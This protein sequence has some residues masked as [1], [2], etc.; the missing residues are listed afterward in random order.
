MPQVEVNYLAVLVAAIASMVL[1]GLWYGPLFGKKWMAYMGWAPD[2][3]QEMKKG[4]T[5]G[6]VFQFIGSLVMSYVLVHA[7]IFAGA[8]LKVSGLSAGL[9]AGF[10]NWLGF[11]APVT[12]GAV[13]W[14]GKPAGFWLLNN[15]FYLISL[16]AMGTI[17]A[18]WM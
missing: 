4:A 17:L 7:L 12:L 18:V 8:Y 10:W 6:Y 2:K 13:L 14:E 16:L 5:K 15:G 3:A 11:V 9:M 1:G